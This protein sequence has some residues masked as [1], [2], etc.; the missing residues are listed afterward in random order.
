MSVEM[1]V[2]RTISAFV[3]SGCDPVGHTTAL[4][5]T[6]GNFVPSPDATV[7]DVPEVAGDGAVAT[8]EYA[9]F[10][11]ASDRL[12][13]GS[14]QLM[15]LVPGVPREYLTVRG[16]ADYYVTELTQEFGSERGYV[17]SKNRRLS[18]IAG[19]AVAGMSF[20]PV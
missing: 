13:L 6:E 10:L 19:T 17:S 15:P 7:S 20:R 2:T 8:V 16:R 18:V 1:F 14:V 11:W 4:N 3:E 12:G 5:G 9:K